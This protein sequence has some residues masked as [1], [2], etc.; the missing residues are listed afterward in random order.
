MWRRILCAIKGHTSQL[1]Y[2]DSNLS[3]YECQRCKAFLAVPSPMMLIKLE[4]DKVDAAPYIKELARRN[5][6]STD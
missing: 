1:I 5:L 3:V 4:M 2:S 6:E